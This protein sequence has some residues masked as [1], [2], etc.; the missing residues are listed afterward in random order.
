MIPVS[1]DKS[2]TSLDFI[3]TIGQMY[4]NQ[5]EHIRLCDMMLKQFQTFVRERYNLAS[6][7]MNTEFMETLATKSDVSLDKIKQIVSHENLIY[8][9]SI[10]E[11]SMIDFHYLLNS[12]YKTCK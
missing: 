6:R 10:T 4:F 2:N 1:E 12:F 3:Q 9:N 5:G 7:D 8:R 11:N